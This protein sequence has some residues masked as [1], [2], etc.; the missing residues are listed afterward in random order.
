MVKQCTGEEET[1][2]DYNAT[3]RI[4]DYSGARYVT[5][6]ITRYQT[7]CRRAQ[8]HEEECRKAVQS[9]LF[10]NCLNTVSPIAMETETLLSR[11]VH[12]SCLAD[13]T[14]CLETSCLGTACKD[15]CQQFTSPLCQM[16]W[17]IAETCRHWGMFLPDSWRFTFDCVDPR[18]V[19]PTCAIRV[20]TI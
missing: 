15:T 18:T 11:C 20:Q 13:E 4:E 17:Q 3:W 5:D 12:D 2:E 19:Q 16:T 8:K 9:P 14:P 7:T 1:E 6:K 10:S